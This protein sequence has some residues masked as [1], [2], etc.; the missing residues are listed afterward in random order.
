MSGSDAELNI[1]HNA[2]YECISCG[3]PEWSASSKSGCYRCGAQDEIVPRG[4]VARLRRQL[5]KREQAAREQREV[6]SQT[7]HEARETDSDEK[8]VFLTVYE[9]MYYY[10]SS[11]PIMKELISALLELD[12]S[13]DKND[14]GH[15]P[16]YYFQSIPAVVEQVLEN[17]RG[18]W[19]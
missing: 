19:D 18:L 9:V 17:Y 13:I 5:A 15:D 8:P 10:R 7:S 2:P 11:M 14:M 1:G 6:H 12:E 3:G 4:T 16:L